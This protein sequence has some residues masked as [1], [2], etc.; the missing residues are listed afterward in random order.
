MSFSEVWKD[1]Q[2]VDS[3]KNTYEYDSNN[4]L[5]S[6]INEIWDGTQWIT[7]YR[8]TSVYNESGKLISA[9]AELLGL[10]LHITR[11]Y[12]SE[13]NLHSEI[14]IFKMGDIVLSNQRITYTY[15]SNNIL[16]FESIEDMDNDQWVI[17]A[18]IRLEYDSNNNRTL[19]FRETWDKNDSTWTNDLQYLYEY[20]ANDNNTLSLYENWSVSDS[21]W[22]STRRHTYEYDNIGNRLLDLRENADSTQWNNYTQYTYGY[23]GDGDIITAAYEKWIDDEWTPNNGSFEFSNPNDDVINFNFTACLI[24][25]VVYATLTDIA[26]NVVLTTE[27]SLLQNYPNPFNPTTTISYSIPENGLVK[28]KVYDALGGEVA[29]LVNENQS[30]GTH[31]VNFNA[32]GLSSG[33][34]FYRIDCGKYSSTKKLILLR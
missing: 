8:E 2:W 11:D 33:V 1:S 19:Y 17:S 29:T 18:Q 15:D 9:D 5:I 13:G 6:A 31:K 26:D 24:E 34:Y 10:I 12:N 27:Y 21:Q 4:N 14:Y 23:D 30:W 16:V 25:D 22:V 28:L 32:T 20:D 3:T 7:E